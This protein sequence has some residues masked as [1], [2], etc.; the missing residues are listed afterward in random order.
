MFKQKGCLQRKWITSFNIIIIH[1]RETILQTNGT[2]GVFRLWTKSIRSLHN[3]SNICNR[4]LKM[5][6]CLACPNKFMRFLQRFSPNYITICIL[7]GLEARKCVSLQT[8]VFVKLTDFLCTNIKA[9]RLQFPMCINDKWHKQVYV[10]GPWSE[11][12][13]L[14]CSLV[15]DSCN[16]SL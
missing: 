6:V 7:L 11:I 5:S 4:I 8:S 13:Y 1:W 2:I 10:T 15:V 16:E 3:L 9:I 12:Y 14:P